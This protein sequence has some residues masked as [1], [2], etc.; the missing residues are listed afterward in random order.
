[1]L[2][3]QRG[4]AVTDG[5]SK[6]HFARM[7][8]CTGLPVCVCLCVHMCVLCKVKYLFF[9]DVEVVAEE[10]DSVSSDQGSSPYD[11]P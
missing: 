8:A 4:G 7:C 10:V 9:R 2:E 6:A 5:E 1:M 11:L 3:S